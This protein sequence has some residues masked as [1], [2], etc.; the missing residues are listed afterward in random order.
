MPTCNHEKKRGPIICP[1]LLHHPLSDF[2]IIY[3]FHTCTNTHFHQHQ[4]FVSE[5]GQRAE[6]MNGGLNSRMERWMDGWINGRM[7]GWIDGWMR[8]E[9]VKRSEKHRLAALQHRPRATSL[10]NLLWEWVKHQAG[11]MVADFLIFNSR[12]FTQNWRECRD[13]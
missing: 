6:E 13:I 12:P 2:L 3:L 10:L 1:L 4:T 11:M 9:D 7:G 5:V 8:E